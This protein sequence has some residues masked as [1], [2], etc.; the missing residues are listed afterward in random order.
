MWRPSASQASTA[1]F[2]SSG[3]AAIINALPRK[4][5]KH[6]IAP[7]IH[8]DPAGKALELENRGRDAPLVFQVRMA[9][10]ILHPG[11]FGFHADAVPGGFGKGREGGN[12]DRRQTDPG[13]QLFS[14]SA[15]AQALPVLDKID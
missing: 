14:D 11:I 8:P 9:P 3:W 15:Q 12:R 7:G 2:S 6:S 10:G 4:M 5:R 1:V 13:P